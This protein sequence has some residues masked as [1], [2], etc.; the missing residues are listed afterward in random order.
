MENT[1]ENVANEG[2][3]AVMVAPVAVEAPAAVPAP[4]KADRRRGD[5]KT[6]NADGTIS[7]GFKADGT[8]RSKPGRRA[9]TA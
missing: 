5:R 7:Y 6:V 4:A 2:F 9:K 3:E 8:P 1:V